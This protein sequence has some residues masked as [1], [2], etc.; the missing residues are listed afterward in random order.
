M[1]RPSLETFDLARMPMAKTHGQG[2]EHI[3]EQQKNTC[4]DVPVCLHC[5]RLMCI[6]ASEYI[7]LE[8]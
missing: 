3:S 6:F 4:T 1:H 5:S 7:V 8:I 2:S